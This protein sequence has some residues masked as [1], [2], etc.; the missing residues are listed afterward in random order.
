MGKKT[1]F[2]PRPPALGT[3]A[4][5]NVC[6]SRGLKANDKTT[7]LK[8]LAACGTDVAAAE[9]AHKRQTDAKRRQGPEVTPLPDEG[10]G[11]LIEINAF[12]KH[13]APL[14]GM[15]FGEF[16]KRVN[17]MV[18]YY[19]KRDRNETPSDT[20]ILATKSFMMTAVPP[21]SDGSVWLF[22]NPTR[23]TDAF[24]GVRDEWLG[25]RLGLDISASG[26]FR[27]TFG[28]KAGHVDDVR[29]PTFCDTTWQSLVLWDWRGITRPLP[30][31]P[32]GLRG[33]E[34]VVAKPPQMQHIYSRVVRLRL[35]K[36]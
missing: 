18:S 20:E 17:A 13:I 14:F 29:Q 30:G 3:V 12:V 34:E 23:A 27:L 28:F 25:H 21:R 4:Y 22:R 15:S 2:P 24:K 7:Y 1:V 5:E 35:H 36:R 6:K 33:L 31:T 10:L 16:A 26:E 32:S 11:I 19:E 9:T 8:A